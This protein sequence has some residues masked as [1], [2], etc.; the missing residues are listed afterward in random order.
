MSKFLISYNLIKLLEQ[1]LHAQNAVR[2]RELCPIF[3]VLC[4]S[5]STNGCYIFHCLT[6]ILA[7]WLVSYRNICCV[8][9]CQN[10]NVCRIVYCLSRMSAALSIVFQECLPY[11]LS[12][13]FQE[14]LPYCLLSNKM[15][16][17]FPIVLQDCLLSCQLFNNNFCR[18]SI[19][20]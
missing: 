7:V 3:E 6:I 15:S 12:I 10:K 9:Y 11:C 19:Y 20:S 4:L 5:Y 18:L 1:S 14:C 13:V 8:F 17:L 2:L 16:A